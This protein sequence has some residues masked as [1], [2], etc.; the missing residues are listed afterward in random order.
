MEVEA[1]PAAVQRTSH[2]LHAW[3]GHAVQCGS[4]VHRRILYVDLCMV[5]MYGCTYTELMSPPLHFLQQ[6]ADVTLSSSSDGCNPRCRSGIV[7][8]FRQCYP[9]VMLRSWEFVTPSFT[10]LPPFS[11]DHTTTTTTTTLNQKSSLPTLKSPWTGS[12]TGTN[13]QLVHR[14]LQKAAALEAKNVSQ[15]AISLLYWFQSFNVGI[16]WL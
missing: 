3:V 11:F 2:E 6:D 10:V 16:T 12:T 4:G 5:Y 13:Q 14:S 9:Y 15:V 8:T 7:G 1:F